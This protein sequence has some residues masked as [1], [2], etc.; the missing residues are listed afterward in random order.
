M[1]TLLENFNNYQSLNFLLV[2]YTTYFRVTF[3]L[4]RLFMSLLEIR[5][6]SLLTNK[7]IK[8]FE[9]SRDN[10]TILYC[11][12]KFLLYEDNYIRYCTVILNFSYTSMML[13]KSRRVYFWNRK[14]F[15]H[16]HLLLKASTEAITSMI[17][18]IQFVYCCF[19]IRHI[20]VKYDWVYM[21]SKFS[22]L[23]SSLIH[24]LNSITCKLFAYF[25]H[26]YTDKS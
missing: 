3:L 7:E 11:D 16:Y 4:H 26:F 13:W 22:A 1:S 24:R 2:C 25:V 15:E 10:D 6:Y 8:A 21:Y 23:I 14:R 18:V 17:C 12:I 20:F 19:L 5:S 9:F